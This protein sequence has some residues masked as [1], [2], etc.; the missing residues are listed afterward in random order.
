MQYVSGTTYVVALVVTFAALAW[1][2]SQVPGLLM[3]LFLGMRIKSG[4][5]RGLPHKYG[6]AKYRGY[7]VDILLDKQVR[8]L[9]LKAEQGK[10]L[11]L[12]LEKE[13]GEQNFSL[14]NADLDAF[15][16]LRWSDEPERVQNLESNASLLEPLRWFV[17][18]RGHDVRVLQIKGKTL[19]IDL[20][21]NTFLSSEKAARELVE[22]AWA[23][24]EGLRRAAL[25]PAL[26]PLDS[27]LAQARSFR[28]SGGGSGYRDVT[29]DPE[30]VVAGVA[31]EP[32]ET[33]TLSEL[34]GAL[35]TGR[36]APTCD[37]KWPEQAGFN[38]LTSRREL[39][40]IFAEPRLEL[41]FARG[42]GRTRLIQRLR[43][44][45]CMRVAAL[46]VGVALTMLAAISSD[47]LSQADEV[48]RS[49]S[50][51]STEGTV[52]STKVREYTV[53]SC[54][55]SSSRNSSS[56]NCSTKTYY[57]ADIRYDY[58]VGGHPFQ[59]RRWS[60]QTPKNDG[61]STHNEAALQ[62]KT[63]REGR[64]VLV[65]YDPLDP[66]TAALRRGI[67]DEGSFYAALVAGHV[68]PWLSLAVLIFLVGLRL[69]QFQLIRRGP[70][71]LSSCATSA[72]HRR[73]C[74]RGA[75]AL[76]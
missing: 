8:R 61:H 52:V 76:G 3:Q 15:F 40:F 48:F 11:G 37:V 25:A 66:R 59:A 17:R 2:L 73:R 1:T 10:R 18:A 69:H 43:V 7:R 36:I 33:V 29:T 32:D 70:P 23:A 30:I 20:K 67:T 34:V 58:R 68:F 71:P 55:P 16:K 4:A 72:A 35:H 14:A 39:A 44:L 22:A 57:A 19:R 42:V 49:Q 75:S 60:V 65:Y 38:P 50:W 64:R 31:P 54:S 13:R 21:T 6:L 26:A 51:P 62:F 28:R 41:S 63:F 27:T 74:G 5:L 56:Q 45:A 12:K 46:I 24:F 9:T 47:S 53:K